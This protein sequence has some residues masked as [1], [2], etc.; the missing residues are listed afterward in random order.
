M[1]DNSYYYYG[2][3]KKI[4]AVFGTLFNN[5]HTGK[6]IAGKLTAVTRVPLAYGPKEQC[7][8]R[9]RQNTIDQK[10]TEIAVKVP[11]MSFEITSISYDSAAKLNRLNQEIVNT[12]TTNANKNYYWQTV[13]Y[14]IGMQLSI[15]ARTQDDAL[16]IFEQIIPSFPPEYS[17]TV[18]DLAV[19]GTNTI[20]PIILTGTTFS[21]DYEGDFQT[22]RRTLIYTL[23]FNIKVQ[24]AS[25]TNTSAVIKNV[26]VNFLNTAAVT[27]AFPL[28]KINV[29]LGDMAN[30]T[31]DDFTTVTTFGFT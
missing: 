25:Q 31:P 21:D 23:D 26:D 14:V 9:I 1:L 17:V 19:P 29:Q 22:S 16:Q 30:D 27:R 7:L 18:V 11:R 3:I 8:A 4:V 15:Y 28:D 5:I 6:V 10:E 20:V 13:P 24:F 2:T 12:N